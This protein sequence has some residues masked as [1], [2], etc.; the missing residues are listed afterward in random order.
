MSSEMMGEEP[1]ITED[2]DLVDII[3]ELYR[4]RVGRNQKTSDFCVGGALCHYFLRDEADWQIIKRQPFPFP[5]SLAYDLDW[6]VGERA[7]ERV[8]EYYLGDSWLEDPHDV[9][10]VQDREDELDHILCYY[11]NAIINANDAGDY[12][13]AWVHVDMFL[14]EFEID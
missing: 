4:G 3:R 11:A 2:S 12:G 6:I 14:K 7:S 8:Q 1:A 13:D 10:D 5:D 9:G